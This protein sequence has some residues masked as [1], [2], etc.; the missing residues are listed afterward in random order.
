ADADAAG[1]RLQEEMV[2][3]ARSN[4]IAIVGP[5]T[6]VA[7]HIRIELN[8]G[9]G[10]AVGVD[11]GWGLDSAGGSG[12][13]LPGSNLIQAQWEIDAPTAADQ[14]THWTLEDSGTGGAAVVTGA[15]HSANNRSECRLYDFAGAQIATNS[16]TGIYIIHGTRYI[17]DN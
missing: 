6:I 17:L 14:I 13:A 16:A 2:A 7:G 8:T 11:G 3:F 10:G 4:G 15:G 12:A 1:R 9:G 5:N